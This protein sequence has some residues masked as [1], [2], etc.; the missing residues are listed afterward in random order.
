M[1][2][3]NVLWALGRAGDPHLLP[4]TLD[5]LIPPLHGP[6][7][8]DRSSR[9]Q[10]QQGSSFPNDGSEVLNSFLQS[11]KF[12]EGITSQSETE[13]IAGGLRKVPAGTVRKPET[14]ANI[15]G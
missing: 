3:R 15:L 14:N 9:V 2:V 12:I 10:S 1:T 8:P 5:A 11:F 13:A 7:L 4:W 6:I